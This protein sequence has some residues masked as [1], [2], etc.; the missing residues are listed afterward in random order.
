MRER[1][2]NRITME[3]APKPA[4]IMIEIAPGELLDK[5]SILEIKLSR[6]SDP[7]KL[8][9][10]RVEL[11]MLGRAR[12]A[13]L[14]STPGLEALCGRLRQ[15]NEML[16]EIEDAIREEEHAGRFGARF[17]ELARSVYRNNDERAALKREINLSLG[18]AIVEEKSYSDYGSGDQPP[19]A[20]ITPATP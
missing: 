1:Q 12:D 2:R 19:V 15:V 17:I 13:S 14:T 3:T 9:N 10:V 5:I 16:W 4:P 6:L 20:T 7:G 18:S 11:A 8:G